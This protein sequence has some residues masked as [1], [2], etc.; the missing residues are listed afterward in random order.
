LVYLK[1]DTSI[2]SARVD[3]KDTTLPNNIKSEV[4]DQNEQGELQAKDP[5]YTPPQQQL[6]Q[7]QQPPTYQQHQFV[8]IHRPIGA[9]QV[10]MSSYYPVYA[11]PSQ[12]HQ[13]LHQYL[14]YVMPIGHGSTQPYNMALQSN[15]S[16]T[17]LVASTR[18]VMPQSVVPEVN[19]SVYKTPMAS[20]SSFNQVPSNQYQQQYVSL[21]Q[22]IHHPPHII[23][24]YEYDGATQEQL[25][26]TQ[27]QPANANAPPQ[28]QSITP[29]P[30]AATL[31]DVS[32]HY[33]ID[34]NIQQQNRTSHQV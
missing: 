5:D 2:A 16:D 14:V 13:Q 8:Y 32:K 11:S 17:N 18:P 26:Y 6:N 3:K 4:F 9:G 22:N 30:A 23:Y 19:P 20:N 15:L 34:N 33:P 28:Y 10:P 21:P 7:N 27:Q 29:A 25:Y 31:L 1:S 12:S 24:G